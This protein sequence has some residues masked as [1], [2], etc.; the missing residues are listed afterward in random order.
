MHG[1]PYV[2]HV[3]PCDHIW[4]HNLLVHRQLQVPSL[5]PSSSSWSW[6]LEED[7]RRQEKWQEEQERLLQ[8]C[9]F[10][11]TNTM[12]ENIFQLAL[13]LCFLC[14]CVLGEIPAGP[15]KNGGRVEEGTAGGFRSRSN[16]WP[17]FL[18]LRV[19]S[20]ISKLTI[21]YIR[22]MCS[23]AISYISGCFKRQLWRRHTDVLSLSLLL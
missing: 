11:F 2:I 14:V 15:A 21:V 17:G 13:E 12:R 5:S 6:D 9:F 18:S 23:M 8:V 20:Q 3:E 16:V 7:R 1:Q 10:S 19:W 4:V 22:Y